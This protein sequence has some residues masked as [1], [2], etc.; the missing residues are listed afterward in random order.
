VTWTK[1]KF[2]VLLSIAAVVVG[3]TYTL[4][5]FNDIVA[6]DK[7]VQAFRFENAE[8]GACRLEILGENLVVKRSDENYRLFENKCGEILAFI[9]D[10]TVKIQEKYLPDFISRVLQVIKELESGER[11]KYRNLYITNSRPN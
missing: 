5:N 6:P 11:L 2:A 8:S 9:N 10:S 3:T 4:A 1:Y 7:P